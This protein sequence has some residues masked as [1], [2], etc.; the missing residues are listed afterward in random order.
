MEKLRDAHMYTVSSTLT[1]IDTLL[2]PPQLDA[3]HVFHI[4][5]I[6]V[7]V[8]CCSKAQCQWGTERPSPSSYRTCLVNAPMNV[9]AFL[10]RGWVGVL[11]QLAHWENWYL[12]NFYSLS[13]LDCPVSICRL[14]DFLHSQRWLLPS[15]QRIGKPSCNPDMPMAQVN[16]TA[17]WIKDRDG[18]WSPETLGVDLCISSVLERESLTS[19]NNVGN[20]K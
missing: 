9:A 13:S 18:K 16:S 20:E 17:D 11:A 5:F 14:H 12:H 10:S 7:V 6:S 19:G 15:K 2:C 1:K 4:F 3:S 8:G